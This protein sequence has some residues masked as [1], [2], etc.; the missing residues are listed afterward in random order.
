MNVAAE[1]N[2]LTDDQHLLL[3]WVNTALDTGVY[4]EWPK[5]AELLAITVYTLIQSI[6]PGE[7]RSQLDVTLS[8]IRITI[9]QMRETLERRTH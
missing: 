1:V 2:A 8:D 6:P 5:M 4:R 3:Q 9:R 7:L